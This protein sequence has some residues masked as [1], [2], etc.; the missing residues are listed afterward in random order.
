MTF[1]HL[2]GRRVVYQ[3]EI[4]LDEGVPPL[5]GTAA[6]GGLPQGTTG[7]S[8]GRGVP[9]PFQAVPAFRDCVRDS[10]RAT[11]RSSRDFFCSIALNHGQRDGRSPTQLASVACVGR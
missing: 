9:Q 1:L 3:P 7:L 10:S 5:P 2:P 6:G 8:D 4:Y 11:L